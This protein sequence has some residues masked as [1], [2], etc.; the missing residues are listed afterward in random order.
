[1]KNVKT[2]Y[3]RELPKIDDGLERQGFVVAAM[4]HLIECK[5]VDCLK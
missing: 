3:Q 1:M 2:Y 5:I 4:K